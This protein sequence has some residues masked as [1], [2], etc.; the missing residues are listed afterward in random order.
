MSTLGWVLIFIG[1]VWLERKI[2]GLEDRISDLENELGE[3]FG[4]D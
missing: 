3:R 4:E 1:I 2:N